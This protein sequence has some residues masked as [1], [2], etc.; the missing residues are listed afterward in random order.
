MA[1]VPWKGKKK[2]GEAP[3]APPPP[4]TST[5]AEDENSAHLL[6]ARAW[7]RTVFGAPMKLEELIRRYENTQ[8]EVMRLA[9]EYA[10]RKLV[11][12]QLPFDGRAYPGAPTCDRNA[13]DPWQ[14]TPE[15]LRERSAHVVACT[16]CP[17]SGCAACRGSGRQI[18]FL[19]FREEPKTEILLHPDMH[20]AGAYP[21]LAEPVFLDSHELE[22]DDVDEVA[23]LDVTEPIRAEMLPVYE[24]KRFPLL[25]SRLDPRT[26]RVRRQQ[27]VR[28]SA[29]RC[30]LVYT[31]CGMEGEIIQWGKAFEYPSSAKE[32]V[33]RRL[34]TWS[35][36]SILWAL[37][38]FGLWLLVTVRVPY[39]ATTNTTIGT[40]LFVGFIA[41]VLTT[42]GVLRGWR[43][44]GKVRVRVMDLVT[45]GLVL[46]MLVAALGVRKASMPRLSAAKEA[47]AAG[48]I[49]EG[50]RL[51]AAL[52]MTGTTE[53]E[54]APLREDVDFAR[55]KELPSAER[56]KRM[57][58]IA[59]HP[60]AHTA[61]AQAE[62]RDYR[63]LEMRLLVAKKKPAP[64]LARLDELFP[65]SQDPDVLEVRAQAFDLEFDACDNDACRYVTGQKAARASPTPARKSRV[66]ELRGRFMVMLEE[67]AD[68]FLTKIQRLKQLRAIEERAKEL[69]PLIPD[70]PDLLARITK[71]QQRVA[72]EREQQPILGSERDLLRE[73]FG[74]IGGD[75]KPRLVFEDVTVYFSMDPG[76]G[77]DGLYIT[78]TTPE[79]RAKGITTPYRVLSVVQKICGKPVNLPPAPTGTSPGPVVWKEGGVRMEARYDA[80]KLV[81]LR[82]AG[83]MASNPKEKLPGRKNLPLKPPPQK[84]RVLAYPG[85]DIAIDGI[86]AGRDVVELKLAPGDHELVV[87]NPFTG[88]HRETFTVADT[89]KEVK[90]VW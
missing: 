77:A 84:V 15:Q 43:P 6:A 59:Q 56:F 40:L 82:V 68:S 10:E 75:A 42:G 28:W 17:G 61:A 13:V 85:G 2:K 78:G 9:T 66:T 50:E 44:G 52:A 31:T 25:R 26:T 65:D 80:G 76:G 1:T 71:V 45:A 70:D 23:F 54:L 27:Y 33:L 89:E 69:A 51:M 7:S 38:M 34:R 19:T 88:E 3:P 62:V 74:D 29:P 11:T 58:E 53:S 36:A 4:Q 20:I 79:V 86:L 60:G 67:D 18:A 24:A 64:V 63:L 72:R 73:I 90:A 12:E 5:L 35:L 87:T 81:E 14:T 32:P 46:V 47:I 57:Q 21:R 16:Q 41:A 83:A 30:A 48:K 55:A 22:A 39:F 37:V 8:V 49:A